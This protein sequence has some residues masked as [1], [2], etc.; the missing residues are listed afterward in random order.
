MAC[1]NLERIAC[2]GIHLLSFHLDFPLDATVAVCHQ[3][4]L[5]STDLHLMP[6]AGFV[7]T[8]NNGF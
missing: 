4:G 7:Q 2:N 8:L 3:F 1:A 5:L 6:C